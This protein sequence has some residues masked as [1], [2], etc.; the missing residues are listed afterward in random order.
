MQPEIEPVNADNPMNPAEMR[1]VRKPMGRRS[2]AF[3][4]WIALTCL[5][6]A[7]QAPITL[8]PAIHDG[9]LLRLDETT[10][11]SV[12]MNPDTHAVFQQPATNRVAAWQPSAAGPA[13]WAAKVMRD[14]E[15]QLHAVWLVARGSGKKPAVDRFIDIWHAQTAGQDHQWEAASRIW[16]GYVG[17]ICGRLTQLRSGRLILPFARW[18]PDQR[19]GPPDGCNAS[20]VL[21]SDDGGKTWKESPARLVSPCVKDYNGDNVGAVEP[22]V[23]ELKDGRIWMLMRTQTGF[24]Y[25][26]FSRDGINWSAAQPTQFHSSTGPAEICRLPDGRI[27][28]FWNN[29]EMPERVQGEGVYGGRDA[30]HAAVSSDDGK[31]WSGFREVYLDPT[32]HQSPPRTG[33]RGTA[34][35]QFKHIEDSRLLFASGQGAKLRVWIA[36]D[37]DWL[38][39]TTSADDFAGGVANWSVFKPFGPAQRWWRDRVQGCALIAHPTKPGKKILHLSKPDGKNADGATWNFP[40]GRKGTATVSFQVNQGFQGATVSLTDRFYDPTDDRGDTNAPC[41]VSITASC[42]LNGA[43]SVSPGQFHL[44]AITWNTDDRT[45]SLKLDGADAGRV[46][47]RASTPNGLCYLRLRST[48]RDTDTAGFYVESVKAEVVPP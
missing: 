18:L 19:R 22:V 25:E 14:R 27:V 17:A 9:S 35:P 12:C 21:Y 10:A 4:I 6:Q 45:A 15:G 29:C 24:L 42:R 47:L 7:A 38:A 46:T 31:T 30:L 36:I 16:E 20:T 32:R 26:S 40:A 5:S 8:G 13:L 2:V 23:L 11:I 33:D 44:L 28:L 37:P 39:E 48:A 3:S 41:S 34:Y 43:A 1:S